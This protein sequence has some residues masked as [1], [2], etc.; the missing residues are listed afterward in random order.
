L[1]WSAA[2]RFQG[3]HH[4]GSGANPDPAGEPQTPGEFTILISWSIVPGLT[5]FALILVL[6]AM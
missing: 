1:G 6:P 5:S 4:A 3:F 2:G